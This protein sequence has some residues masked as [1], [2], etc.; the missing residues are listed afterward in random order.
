MTLSLSKKVLLLFSS[1]TAITLL[2]GVTAFSGLKKY[3][4]YL[5]LVTVIK[6]FQLSTERLKAEQI[7]WFHSDTGAKVEPFREKIEKSKTLGVKIL[8]MTGGIDQKQY[9]RLLKLPLYLDYYQTAG[10][11]LLK[12]LSA[13]HEMLNDNIALMKNMQDGCRQL[14]N[15]VG[16]C[17]DLSNLVLAFQNRIYHN[18]NLSALPELKEIRQAV[19]DL[20]DSHAVLET[21]DQYIGNLEKN[22][23]NYLAIQDRRTFLRKTADHF[24]EVTDDVLS[25]IS[26][27]N[28]NSSD[29]LLYLIVFMGG[30]AFGMNLL[31][32]GLA[33]KYFDRFI[34]TQKKAIQ[35]VKEGKYPFDLPRPSDD[36][37]G[38]L[39]SAMNALSYSLAESENRYLTIMASMKS[40]S[41]ICSPEMTI[42][43]MNPAMIDM[44]GRDATGE[45]CY[46]AIHGLKT[47]C[48]WCMHDKIQSRISAEKEIF[49]PQQ[50]KTYK[51]I[52]SPLI[53]KD[54][55][56]SKMI[57]Y[58]DITHLKEMDARLAQAQKMESIGN[59][60]GGIAHD[61][62]NLL[63]PIVGMAE[64]L[65][66]DL[67]PGSAEH[68]KIEEIYKAGKR[69]SELV[70]QILTFS[71]QSEQKKIPIHLQQILREVMKLT[72]ST[73]PSNIQ[74]TQD[75]QQDCPMVL[76]HPT[77]IH[78]VAMNL[79]TNAYHAVERKS[80]KIDVRLTETRIEAGELPDSILAPGRYALLSVS[81]TG[82]GINPAIIDKIFDPYFTTKEQGK[83]TGLGLAVVFGILKEHLGDIKVYSEWGNGTTFNVYLP[84]IA[85]SEKAEIIEQKDVCSNGNERILL[86]DDETSIVRLEKQMLERLGYTVTTFTS[87]AEALEAF[88]TNPRLFDLVVSDMTMPKMTGDQLA[89]KLTALRPD[90]PIIICTGFSE[91]INQEN[92]TAFGVKGLLMKPIVKSEMAKMVRTVLDKASQGGCP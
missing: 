56:I 79:I 8:S 5:V 83:G 74:I 57:V 59:L 82:D 32:W 37:I 73:I 14:P 77:Q 64:L 11:E 33:Q 16:K 68:E 21:L 10:V 28:R 72:R 81:D 18:R 90:I 54:G 6:D 43:Y 61:F 75:I 58:D 7:Q 22:Y 35:A 87:S 92:V 29:L 1:L 41:Y 53:H 2:L 42:E 88:R 15:G 65:L 85:K 52:S 4:N 76:A 67:P 9:A 19:Q 48:S 31:F 12:R 80:G 30:A 45:R 24:F 63:F 47:K 86:V 49:S 62:N 55:T 91:R 60:A 44:V 13:D 66:E 78:Q 39:T 50:G 69:G 34:Q 70:N 84:I 89:R 20:G 36:E 27:K 23:Q 46:E 38:E 25:T 17:I 3:S 51:I 26:E 40:P 71:R